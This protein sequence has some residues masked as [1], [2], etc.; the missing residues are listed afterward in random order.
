M[1]GDGPMR[2]PRG[3]TAR[4]KAGQPC[5]GQA[6]D[7]TDR[8]RMHAG[9]KLAEHKARGA[10]VVELRNWGLRETE[11]R[12]PGEQML[13]LVAQ[14]SDRAEFYAA[15]LQEAYEAAERLRDAAVP[16]TADQ[17]PG[18]RPNPTDAERAAT[19]LDRIFT[20]GG[21]AALIGYKYGA[22]GKDGNL[23]VAE[24]AIR[25]LVALENDERDRCARFCKMAVDAKI[26]ERQVRLAEE[27]G[28]LVADVI[29]GALSD[30]GID[31]GSP[32]ALRVVS[33][34]L[35]ALAVA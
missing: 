15:L 19:D 12:D 21:V 25:G 3:C 30:L 8:C 10:V 26:A 31:P 11:L 33:S 29:R 20:T 16:P 2:G 5:H 23:Y 9:R 27:H 28:R 1:R 17:V 13:R 18:Q 24:E 34:R 35:R 4:T 32:A 7:G 14:S 22:A 6:V